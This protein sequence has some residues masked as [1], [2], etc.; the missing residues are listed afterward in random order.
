MCLMAHFSIGSFVSERRKTAVIAAAKSHTRFYRA[1]G[2]K[3]AP[4][5]REK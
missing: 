5:W 3:D 1:V 4:T 2:A